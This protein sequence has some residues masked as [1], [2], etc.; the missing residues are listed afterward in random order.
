MVV[1]HNMEYRKLIKFGSNSHVISI[2]QA[3]IKKYNLTKGDPIYIETI[4]DNLIL[5][6][7]P[8]TNKE[9][10]VSTIQ[11]QKDT[12]IRSIKRQLFSA[13]VNNATTVILN[14]DGVAHKAKE[15]NTIVDGYIA[16]EIVE[17]TSKKII[18]KAYINSEEVEIEAF[19]RR[20][21]N[22]IRS[23]TID[24][25]AELK[26]DKPFEQK[27]FLSHIEEREKNIDRII[28]LVY[29]VIR[30]RLHRQRTDKRTEEPLQLLKYWDTAGHLEKIS[31]NIE[32]IATI[33]ATCTKIG[34]KPPGTQTLLETLEQSLKVFELI[35][36]AYYKNNSQLA[37]SAA[38]KIKKGSQFVLAVH[39]DVL[40]KDVRLIH[41]LQELIT[42]ASAINKMT[43]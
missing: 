32:I 29:R 17:N 2:P 37:Y 21:D 27:D 24:F 15:I 36:K 8:D 20:V 25:I 41:A 28:R 39:K 42:L 35:M 22:S 34:G 4:G 7:A 12:D 14:G 23:M 16:L 31:D 13:Y 26:K 18:C 10:K 1:L 11:I 43:Y 19:L 30:E 6:P 9:D 33:L 40:C 5:T 3:W 38:D